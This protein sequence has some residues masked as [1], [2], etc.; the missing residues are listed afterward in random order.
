MYA[1]VTK[2]MS[3]FFLSEWRILSKEGRSSQRF[4]GNVNVHLL[5]DRTPYSQSLFRDPVQNAPQ[6]QR[7]AYPDHN[8]V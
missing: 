5:H 2:N 1:T 7:I 8:V 3:K 6:V 4:G